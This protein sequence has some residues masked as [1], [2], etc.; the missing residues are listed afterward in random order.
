MSDYDTAPTKSSPTTAA[1]AAQA[2]P[3]PKTV[4]M[5]PSAGFTEH[6]DKIP[7]YEHDRPHKLD[8]TVAMAVLLRRIHEKSVIDARLQGDARTKQ[9]IFAADDAT[10]LVKEALQVNAL[11]KPN[12]GEVKTE[13]SYAL[14]GLSHLEALSKGPE[15]TRLEKAR[16]DL[17][18]VVEP[19]IFAAAD[20]SARQD[21]NLPAMNE[22]E[23]LEM[24]GQAII[25]A[26]RQQALFIGKMKGNV[27]LAQARQ[28]MTQLRLHYDTASDAVTG[29]VDRRL[30][31][32]LNPDVALATQ[33]MGEVEQT[34]TDS[35]QPMPWDQTF[36]TGFDAEA[37]F[38]TLMGQGDR[39]KR[40]FTGTIDPKE[41]IKDIEDIGSGK[42]ASARN[43]SE[44]KFSSPQQA[45]AGIGVAMEEIFRRQRGAVKD[46]TSAIG[47]PRLPKEPSVLD[48]LL[49]ILVKT[50]LAGAAGAIG[51]KLSAK[52][53]E[54]VERTFSTKARESSF[55]F[56]KGKEGDKIDY[57]DA[58]PTAQE[59]AAKAAI[60]SGA[61]VTTMVAESAKDSFKEF[62]KS[63]G[64]KVIMATVAKGRGARS[65]NPSLVE[66]FRERADHVL[67]DAQF[68]ERVE[69]LGLAPALGQAE[70]SALQELFRT[71]VAEL[72]DA[73]TTQYSFVME[74][75]QNF[76][77]KAY[78]DVSEDVASNDHHKYNAK[79][80][81]TKED[82][83]AKRSAP[84][85]T[86]EDTSDSKLDAQ[87]MDENKGALLIQA[88]INTDDF[89]GA[90]GTPHVE[91]LRLPDA[92]EATLTHF[93]R[94]NKVLGNVH[95][96]K[97]FRLKFIAY[98][99]DFTVNVGV[100]ADHGIQESTLDKKE[101]AALRVIAAREKISSTSVQVAMTGDDAKYSRYTVREL[102]RTLEKY[103][104]VIQMSQ[105]MNVLKG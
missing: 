89:L 32:R 36:A 79:D 4:P 15:K 99:N 31:L 6:L 86:K 2:Q 41:A 78:N 98:M 35:A 63:S 44:S 96:N 37:R 46:A 83:A 49:E 87:G 62:F 7:L 88:W 91:S 97:Q 66:R 103:I 38:L 24:A 100:G 60:S 18:H 94:E 82:K 34:L 68:E 76:K 58:K 75:W 42:G 10:E 80:A 13:L 5:T 26:C 1:P 23:L 14:G 77:A 92:E 53:K 55:M 104:K 105:H 81:Q 48:T 84:E 9:A 20:K 65:N 51:A 11:Q 74:E 85:A 73:Y 64:Y 93:T 22:S 19:K 33:G 43:W 27:D 70:P 16:L 61:G 8:G 47:Q 102:E 50:A 101:L 25:A 95:M 21:G 12:W 39:V 3:A 71:L 54:K 29:I 59:A 52:V 56:Q 72:G 40:K 57:W 67:E 45:V 90:T 69:F 30:F 28:I 17:Q